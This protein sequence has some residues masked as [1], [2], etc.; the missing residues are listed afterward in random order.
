MDGLLASIVPGTAIVVWVIS[1]L[2]RPGEGTRLRHRIGVNLLIYGIVASLAFIPLAFVTYGEPQAHWALL[3]FFSGLISIAVSGA[4]A[5][6][7]LMMLRS[8]RSIS[9]LLQDS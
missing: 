4:I 6:A 2:R 1:A 5:L 9:S 3:L 8:T 7:N